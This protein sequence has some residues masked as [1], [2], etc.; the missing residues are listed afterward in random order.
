M[1]FDPKSLDIVPGAIELSRNAKVAQFFLISFHF[2][3]LV[4]SASIKPENWYVS[5]GY[6]TACLP[7]VGTWWWLS[8]FGF[9]FLYQSPEGRMH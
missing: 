2:S 7:E 8:G 5:D 4:E 3:L 9:L 1:I 6:E